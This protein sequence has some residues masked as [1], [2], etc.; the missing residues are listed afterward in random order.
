MNFDDSKDE[1]NTILG[2]SGNVTFSPEEKQRALTKAW[3]DPYV[4]RPVWDSSLTFTTTTYEYARPSGISVVMDI[5]LTPSTAENPEP[6]ASDLW[7]VTGSTI[8][9][10]QTA[11]NI[12][13]NSTTLYV[14]G[15]YKLDPDTDTITES[16]LK[17]YVLSVAGYET[18]T[19]LGHKKANLFLKN[20]TTMGELV[21]LRREL[22]Q[23]VADMRRSLPKYYENA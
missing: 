19:L 4:V 12:I 5:Y 21:T 3:R 14:R 16:N 8:R 7:E 11:R 1:L 18:L 9:F 22:K 2:D 17:E 6:I 23:D 15:R 20:D 10:N 13:P